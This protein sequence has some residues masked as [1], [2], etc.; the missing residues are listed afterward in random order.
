MRDEEGHPRKILEGEH[1]VLQSK[2]GELAEIIK[3]L[4]TL[5]GF[6]KLEEYVDQL[7]EISRH[8]LDAE[9]HH[10]RPIWE[11]SSIPPS[12]CCMPGAQRVPVDTMGYPR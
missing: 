11:T 6:D 7:N 1:E 3:E 5:K 4:D 9:S 12:L 8:L 10:N 2:L